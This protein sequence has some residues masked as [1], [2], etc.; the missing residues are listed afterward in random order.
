M[1]T[2]IASTANKMNLSKPA[3]YTGDPESV[4]ELERCDYSVKISK[5][6]ANNNSTQL[7]AR[8]VRIYSDGIFDLFHFGHAQQL[9]QAKGAFPSVYLIVGGNHQQNDIF[10]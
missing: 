3:P 9:A 1:S 5:D 2:S 7:P 10:L 8:R 6:G 4:A